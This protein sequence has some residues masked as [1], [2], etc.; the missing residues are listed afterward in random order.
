MADTDKSFP[1]GSK[2]TRPVRKATPPVRESTESVRRS[3]LGRQIMVSFLLI[4]LIP[5][6]IVATVNFILAQKTLLETETE[7]LEAI[8]VRQV[9]SIHTYLHE[10]Q[11][12]V[13][14]VSASPGAWMTLQTLKDI[15]S[16]QIETYQKTPAYKELLLHHSRGLKKLVT[17]LGF[18]RLYL[19]NAEGVVVYAMPDIESGYRDLN[20]EGNADTEMARLFHRTERLMSS[21]TS[22]FRIDPTTGE[23]A[24]FIS[25]PVLH[26][27]RYLGMVILS[28]KNEDIFDVVSDYSGMSKSGEIIL[29]SR[30][31]D[32]ILFLNDVRHIDD[33][34]FNYSVPFT[35]KPGEAMTPVQLAVRG[36]SGGSLVTD[37]RG[38]DVLAGWEYLPNLRMGLVLKI[39]KDE[40]FEP[41]DYLSHISLS[42]AGITAIIVIAVAILLSRGITQ[43]ILT[44]T[45]AANRMADG[46]LTVDIPCRS[47]TEIGQLAQAARTMTANFKS[48]IGKVKIAGGEIAKTAQHISSAARQ[49]VTI[50]EQTGT[51]SVEVNATAR[52][53]SSTAK[54]LTTT[55]H[56]VND[57]TQKVA[58]NAESDL[59]LLQN[60]GDSMSE[61]QESNSDVSDQLNLIQQKATAI[62]SIV[63]TM[64]KVADQTNLLSLNAAIEARK[65]GESGRGFSVVATEIRRLADQAALSTLEIESS[66]KDMMSAVGTGVKSMN[67]FSRKVETSVEE[68]VG[69]SKRLTDVIQQVQGLPPRFDQILEGMESQS[70][71]AEQINEA[72]AHLSE[73][74]QQTA[75]AVKQTHSM[76]SNLRRSA[77]VLQNEI[78]RF[79]T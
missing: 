11:N 70:A 12:I 28:P 16:D 72:M 22:D 53:I 44:L 49:Q 69:I 33:A 48:L 55:M 31:G 67:D 24:L 27:G 62:S 14:L 73:S 35:P 59:D 45:T 46:D 75:A 40:V 79:K 52:Q 68:I 15:D 78:E 61:L 6:G 29:A 74:A 37:Y 60:L 9:N 66:V 17:E 5:L 30:E 43:P 18:N 42:V 20:A 13:S 54:E 39:D 76:L 23:P 32:Q 50:A 63:L 1:F 2:T 34:A 25:A 56:N 21:Q 51:S 57:I 47:R 36:E 4:A 77:D 3:R 10:T 7:Y 64:T 65:A 71:G 41:I 58:L 38:V 8:A 26:D 19:V